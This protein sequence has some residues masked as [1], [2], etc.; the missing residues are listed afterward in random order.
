M[1]H[2]RHNGRD[3]QYE[4][5]RGV[6]RVYRCIC[7]C[8]FCSSRNSDVTCSGCGTNVDCLE[9]RKRFVSF[10]ICMLFRLAWKRTRGLSIPSFRHWTQPWTCSMS[11]CLVVNLSSVVRPY[12]LTFVG[13]WVQAAAVVSGRCYNSLV[14]TW[15]LLNRPIFPELFQVRLFEVRLVAKS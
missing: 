11:N 10:I 5:D 12:N 4:C 15:F 3:R 9:D 14:L 7:F 6:M 8:I 1:Y 2:S 13:C